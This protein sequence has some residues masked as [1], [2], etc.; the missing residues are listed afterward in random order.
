MKMTGS[1][2]SLFNRAF[3]KGIK[4]CAALG[5]DL[6]FST[7]KELHCAN[8]ENADSWR[9][10]LPIFSPYCNLIAPGTY[11]CLLGRNKYNE[12]VLAQGA[13]LFDWRGTSFHDEAESLRLF[14]GAP[15]E[16]RGPG[17][18]IVVTAPAARVIGGRV[19]YT[20]AHWVRP[21][22]RRKGLTAITPRMA[23]ALAMTI[24][25]VDCFATI[26][27]KDIFERGV[28]ER[29]GYPHHQWTVD[30]QN[31]PTGTFPA[32]LLWDWPEDFL[33]SLTKEE[34]E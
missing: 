29:A 32:A 11:I 10:L 6:R 21:D 26:M 24:W 4:D 1:A 22:Y 5:V 30:L 2:R 3:A 13:R 15:D 8:R 33:L 23:K 12:V 25:K 19:A 27:A 9:P 14:Y 20:G 34:G 17:E 28:A 18:A 16:H 31:T 7:L